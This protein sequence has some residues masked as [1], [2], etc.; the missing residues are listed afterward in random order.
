M[1]FSVD[2]CVGPCVHIG[3]CCQKLNY[4]LKQSRKNVFIIVV[5]TCKPEKLKATG[6]TSSEL[7]KNS[8][9]WSECRCY[10]A[11]SVD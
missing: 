4:T 2:L 10:L 6:A 11:I 7:L 3:M 5:S 9:L 8:F 1:S